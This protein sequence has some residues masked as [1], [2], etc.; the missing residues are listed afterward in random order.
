[1]NQRRKV[2]SLVIA[3][4]LGVFGMLA[5]SASHAFAGYYPS[6]ACS[7]T[8]D[9]IDVPIINSPITLGVQIGSPSLPRP[10]G[11]GGETYVGLCYSTSPNGYDGSETT[12]GDIQV[13]F[14]PSTSAPAAE[15]GCIPDQQAQGVA[16]NC[17]ALAAPTY[18]VTPGTGL[19]GD[20]ITVSIPF[21]LYLGQG[22]SDQPTLSP[23][24]VLVGQLQPYAEPGSG[25]GYQLS[26]LQVWADGILLVSA[27]PSTAGAYVNPFGV[28]AES[29]NISQ[30]G[31]CLEGVCIPAGYVESTGNP[32]A[33]VQL[34]NQSFNVAVPKNCVYTNPSGQ[35]P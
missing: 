24:G 9:S 1:M 20:T 3:G 7:T 28:A 23:T 18:S 15:A 11:H 33:G 12:G 5:G 34:L 30:G 2:L 19:A 4:A 26:F 17:T 32:V 31:P 35:C 21:S 22:V 13:G 14:T 16:V 10:G 29:L 8:N 25:V 27:P 6:N